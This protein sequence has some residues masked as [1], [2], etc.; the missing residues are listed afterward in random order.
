MAIEEA[1][2][3]TPQKDVQQILDWASKASKGDFP[4]HA[5]AYRAVECILKHDDPTLL[6]ELPQEVTA[7]IGEMIDV[8][9]SEGKV[10]ISSSVGEADNTDIV[11]QLVRVL[12]GSE[13]AG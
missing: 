6:S 12:E 2:M 3:K 7:W 10:L 11:R 1:G 8:Y 4:M 5:V 9:K 13:R